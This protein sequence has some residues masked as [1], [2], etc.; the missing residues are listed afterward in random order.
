MKALLALLAVALPVLAGERDL[1]PPQLAKP[2]QDNLLRFLEQHQKP[3]RYIPENAKIV[4][5]LPGG[6]ELPTQAPPM[7]PVKQYTVQIVAHRPVPD[8]PEPNRVDVYYYRPNPEKGKP[9]VTVRY[10]V[11]LTNGNQ[12]GQ[13]EVLLNQHTAMSQEE[14]TEAVALAREKSD[15][16]KGVYKNHDSNQVRY[17]YLQMKVNTK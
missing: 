14:V 8:Q 6:A 16:L 10:T 17:E 3:V 7:K 9:G 2:Q 1:I 15:A 11:D 5:T 12:V 13:T 4:G